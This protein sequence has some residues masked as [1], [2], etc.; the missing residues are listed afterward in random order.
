MRRLKDLLPSEQV[1]QGDKVLKAAAE[2]LE[3]R[4]RF[5]DRENYNMAWGLLTSANDY[6]R[7]IEKKNAIRRSQQSRLYLDKTKETL[8]TVK[9]VTEESASNA[10]EDAYRVG[11]RELE[12]GRFST[13]ETAR[14]IDSDDATLRDTT[15][16]GL[17]TF[18]FAS[19]VASL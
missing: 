2:L 6:R 19:T 14:V 11:E 3:K 8:R 15:P 5:T 7:G 9:R 18:P 12:R 1:R 4:K 17:V 13:S 10:K 16:L